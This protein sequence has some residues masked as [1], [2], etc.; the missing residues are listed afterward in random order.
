MP[1]L[2][3]QGQMEMDHY[4]PKKKRPNNVYPVQ[5]AAHDMPFPDRPEERGPAYAGREL[6][7]RKTRKSILP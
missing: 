6:F 4:D 1:Q 3:E 7:K 5:R 2:V